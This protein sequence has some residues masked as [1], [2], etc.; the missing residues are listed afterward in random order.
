MWA[1]A[2]ELADF[3]FSGFLL[4]TL[5]ALREPGGLPIYKSAESHASPQSLQAL[6]KWD[7]TRGR[8][9][10]ACPPVLGYIGWELVNCRD[11]RDC[12]STLST[13]SSLTFI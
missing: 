13:A 2:W 1:A 9:A 8:L 11:G 6:G 4:W 12:R 5:L 10:I 3:L 7:M